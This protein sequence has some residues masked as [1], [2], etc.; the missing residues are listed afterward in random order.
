MPN[1]KIK[2]IISTQFGGKF[3][4]HKTISYLSAACL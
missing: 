4:I 2:G 3:F 1:N